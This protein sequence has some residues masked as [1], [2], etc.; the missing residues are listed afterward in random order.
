MIASTHHRT[1]TLFVG[2]QDLALAIILAAFTF[3]NAMDAVRNTSFGAPPDEWA[4]VTYLH[5]VAV[6]GRLIP[7]YSESRIL[8]ARTQGNYLNHPPLYYT[9][10]GFTGR[11]LG[12]DPVKDYRNF[13]ALSAAL[14]TLGV[15]LWALTG[16]GLGIPRTWII[17][18]TAAVNA[19]PM[20]P[21]LAG[22]INNDNMA[23][24]G[25]AITF[26]GLV[27]LRTWP[28]GAFYIGA[29]GV[30][31]VLLS[32]ATAAL[33]LC[34]FFACWALP[35]ARQPGSPLRNRHFIYALLGAGLV[36]GGYYLYALV[37]FGTPFPKAAILYPPAPL[38]EPVAIGPFAVDFS[39]AMLRRLPGIMSHASLDPL[40]G[41]LHQIFWVMLAMPLLAWLVTRRSRPDAD[42]GMRT[43]FMQALAATILLHMLVVWN[44]YNQTGV[45][46]GMQPR[47]YSY[48]L[49]G[50][51]VFCFLQ[52]RDSRIGRILLGIF[53][54]SA[55]ILLGVG[56]ALTARAQLGVHA[57][58]AEAAKS[59]D[60]VRYP[61]NSTSSALATR[62]DLGP[63]NAGYV[64]TL[65]LAGGSAKA[66]GWAIDQADRIA[67]RGVMVMVGD[68]LIGSVETG[69]HRADVAKALNSPRAGSAGF[70]IR[71]E[72]LPPDTTTC[73]IRLA[74][75]QSDGRLVLLHYGACPPPAQ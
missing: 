30:I 45:P 65:E 50:L 63:G 42:T 31:T 43:A 74:A 58:A 29:I 39:K 12:W 67:A 5:E 1:D 6:D 54:F 27:Q 68:R 64:D 47:Y 15:L 22:S 26:F 21:Y 32:K 57:A 59:V 7:D 51:F 9:A 33:F 61:A 55:S 60:V 3:A 40:V 62:I 75:E 17:A 25:I 23:Y 71:I 66:T 53:G 8:P 20:F 56:P 48:V 4:H 52:A 28:R 34:V 49:P 69:V 16:R 14:V 13:R 46:G 10:L 41:P 19:I 36:I 70:S 38:V 11:A 35:Q 73:D 72:K 44:S 37:T 24:L 2:W 18:F